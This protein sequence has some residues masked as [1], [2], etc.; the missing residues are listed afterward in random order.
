VGLTAMARVSTETSTQPRRTTAHARGRATRRLPNRTRVG[1]SKI[2]GYGLF[3]NETI[4]AGETVNRA[5]LLITGK[6]LPRS[7]ARHV[8]HLADGR[9][10][11]PCGDGIMVNHANRPN[12][13]FEI[14][15]RERAVTL[16]ALRRIRRGEEITIDYDG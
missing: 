10:A 3:A 14:D 7:F 5:P 1:L 12:A 2:H 16:I 9:H 15:V 4:A 13:R 6:Q 8:Y 11:L